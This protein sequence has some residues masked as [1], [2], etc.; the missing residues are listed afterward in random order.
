VLVEQIREFEKQSFE[1]QT[2][3]KRGYEVENENKTHD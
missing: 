2:K 1:I 3:I